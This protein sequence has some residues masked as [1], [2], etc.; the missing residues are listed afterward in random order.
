MSAECCKCVSLVHREVL[1]S[2]HKLQVVNNH[3]TD[4]VQVNSMMHGIEHGPVKY[5]K[6]LHFRTVVEDCHPSHNLVSFSLEI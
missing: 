3:M 5:K 4:V 2:H 1:L 6:E